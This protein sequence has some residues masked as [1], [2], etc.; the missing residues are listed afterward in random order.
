[1]DIEALYPYVLPSVRGCPHVTALGA[2]QAAAV[3]FFRR[4][5]LWRK[6][7]P[8]V[9]S[10]LAP[11]TFTA[12]LVGATSGTLAAPFAGP[13]RTDYVMTFSD[14]TT[15]IVAL[16]SGS[17]AV[18]WSSPVS[19]S[20]AATYSQVAYTIPA[21]TDAE[22]S[23]LLRFVVDDHPGHV[24]TPDAGER[25]ALLRLTSADVAWTT[26]R[27]NFQVAPAPVAAGTQ[28]ILSVALQPTPTAMTLPDE[29][30]LVHAEDIAFGALWRLERMNNREWSNDDDAARNRADFERRIGIVAGQAAKGFGRGKRRIRAHYF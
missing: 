14:G 18:S 16:N 17:S 15:R 27:L 11:L 30:G 19:A 6:T 1:M 7:L 23:K 25:D 21:T 2:I 13:S 22:V 28:Y 29:F 26:D 9:S 8:A 10:V 24:A 5:L 4:T 3:E 12:P 20:T